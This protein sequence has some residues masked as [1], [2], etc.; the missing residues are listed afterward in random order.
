MKQSNNIFELPTPEELICIIDNYH[1]NHQTMHIRIYHPK[2]EEKYTLSLLRVEY[3]SGPTKWV[4]A[5]FQLSSWQEIAELYKDIK[6]KDIDIP[7]EA[8]QEFAEKY[9]HLYKVFS[10]NPKAEIKILAGSG[11]LLVE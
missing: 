1:F 9:L 7:S 4:G 6:P 5:S 8:L 3:F 10:V 2:K 11:K